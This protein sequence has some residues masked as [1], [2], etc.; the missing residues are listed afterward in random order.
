MDL[1]VN[2]LKLYLD[3]VFLRF[4]IKRGKGVETT[5]E[6]N[7]ETKEI[8]FD[9]GASILKHIAMLK[10]WFPKRA[11]VCIG[12]YPVRIL[13]KGS[14]VGNADGI[15]PVYV[16]KSSSDIAKWSPQSL[17]E[18]SVL[19]LDADIDT[20]FWF[21]ASAYIKDNE[22][23]ARLRNTSINK[24]HE[25]L[26]IS[27]TWDGLSSALLPNLISQSKAWSMSYAA[28]TVLPSM[29]QPGDAKFNAYSCLGMCASKDFTPIVL[30]DRDR[31]EGYVGVD[32]KGSIIKGSAI[33][34]Y[35]LEMILAKD[36][37]VQEICDLLRPFEARFCGALAIT[38]TSLKI[39]GS[40]ENIL[41]TTL[42]KPLTDFDW[43]TTSLVYVLI[44]MPRKLKDKLTKGKIELAVADWFGDKADLKSVYVSEPM[45]VDDELDRIDVVMLAGGFDTSKLFG[46]IEKNVTAIKNHA[47]ERGFIKKEEWLAIAKNLS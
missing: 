36:T 25:T 37:F 3:K 21:D 32:R 30:L 4:V 5:T 12:D 33:L 41:N 14:A 46:A 23:M 19:G 44:R 9:V 8:P 2:R 47:F 28:L 29:V 7:V 6:K 39:Y 43:A 13:L 10:P 20:H 31:L 1:N 26:V 42:V 18:H 15:L 35:V 34:D 24:V 11:V 40:L 38:G 22:F 16:D 45:Y 27:S 17:D